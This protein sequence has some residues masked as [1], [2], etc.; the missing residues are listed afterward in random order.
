[1]PNTKIVTFNIR[2]PW[3]GDGMN[4]FMHRLGLV[5]DK[6]TEEM[7]DVIA[8][9]EM[10]PKQ[11]TVLERLLPEYAFCG[12]PR[13]A[14][15]TGEGLYI[16]LK[17]DV[18]DTVAYETFWLSPTPHVAGSR[19]SVQSE[20]P[21][22]CNAVQIRNRGNGKMLRVFNVHLDHACPEARVEG[23]KCVLEKVRETNARLVLPTVILGDFNSEP[24]SKTIAVLGEHACPEF[25]DVTSGIL[26]TN[27]DFGR[28]LATSPVKIDYIYATR[29]L[30]NACECA[31]VWDECHA[32]IYLSDHY[33]VYAEFEF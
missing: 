5:Y 3:S 27:H 12:Q 6:I 13:N 24:N 14:D 1:M 8:F 32:G 26:R 11:K 20:Y 33:P 17:K 9:Q 19:F 30:A 31:R 15:Y 22:I 28:N 23:I 21:R 29:E 2:N 16:A 4:A 18:W 25:F 10:M 7:P